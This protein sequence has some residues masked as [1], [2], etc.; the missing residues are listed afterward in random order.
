MPRDLASYNIGID[1]GGTTIKAGLVDKNGEIVHFVKIPTDKTASG[2]KFLD[3]LKSAVDQLLKDKNLKVKN[4]NS[5]GVCSPGWIKD[6]VL[7]A[8]NNLPGCSNVAIDIGLRERTGVPVYVGNDAK[9]ALLGELENRVKLG[10]P[11]NTS[12][13]YATIGTGI[14]GAF[15]S[16]E[17]KLHEMHNGFGLEIGHIIINNTE[18]ARSCTCG[19]KGCF[20]AEAASSSLEKISKEKYPEEAWA[21]D[22]QKIYQAAK[23]GDSKASALVDKQ[24]QDLATGIDSVRCILDPGLVIVGGAMTNDFEFI[25]DRLENA[26]S[27]KQFTPELQYELDRATLINNGGILGAAA[28][29]KQ[30][31]ELHKKLRTS[32]AQ[33]AR[34]LL[35]AIRQ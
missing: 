12:I 8:A 27:Q 21:G 4:I 1:V 19:K 26:L 32:L 35:C 5:I 28:L 9:V 30:D 29:Y 3:D 15:A 20:E 13:L 11:V 14:G 31:L 24:I 10:Q 34:G 7:I 33:S 2:E 23:S 16:K 22:S 17:G 25:K 6:G 18:T